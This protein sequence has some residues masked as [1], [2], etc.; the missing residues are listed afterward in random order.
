MALRLL[1]T[2]AALLAVATSCSRDPN[3]V[4]R[5]YLENGNKYFDRGKYREAS[6]MYRTALQKDAKFGEAYYRLALTNLKMRS[7]TSAIQSLRRAVELL[8][9]EQPERMDARVKLADLY[10]DYA[11]R[12]K[13]ETGIIEEAERTTADL[14][15]A[16]PK[17]FDGHRLKG[18]MALLDAQDALK[19]HVPEQVKS[20]IGVAIS[21]FQLANKVKPDDT[22]LLVLLARAYSASAQFSEAEKIYHRLVE[23]Q[24]EFLPAYMEVYRLYLVQGQFD[25]GEG[26]LKKAIEN[27]PKKYDLQLDLAA[28]YY[29]RK[30]RDDVV[31]VL[32][33][34]KSKAKAFPEVYERVGGFYFRLGDGA[35]AIRQYE[36]G[37]RA[38]G[39]KKNF[40]RKLIIEVLM[41]QGKR[42]EAKTLNDAILAADPKD[43]DALGLQGALLLDKGDLQNA[44]VQL[45]AVV[46]RAPDNFVAHFNLARGLNDKGDYEQARSHFNEAIRL[47]PDYTA[48]RIGLG[49][50]QLARREWEPA[51]KTA[52]EI[53]AYDSQNQSAALIESGALMGSGQFGP[54]REALKRLLGANPSSQDGHFQMGLLNMSEGKFK[55]AEE[56]YRRCYDLNPANSRGLMG[57]VELFMIQKQPDRAMKLLRE[58]MQKFPTRLEL[59]L[60][61]ANVMVRDQKYSQAIA[62]F[63]GLLDKVDRKSTAAADLYVRLGEAQRRTGDTQAGID[64]LKKARDLMP[65]SAMVLNTLALMLD[66]AGQKKEAKAM[67]EGALRVESENAIAL[68][69]LAYIIAESPGGDLD[70]A[71]TFAQR[72]KQKMPQVEEIADTLGWIYLKKNLAD[73]AIEIFRG[74]VIRQPKHPTFRYHLGMALYQ[75]GDK[76]KAKQELQQALASSPSKEEE[77]SIK[78]LIAKIG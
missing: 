10:L 30:R 15:K 59:R 51:I 18:R 35:E 29:A 50:L 60:A 71:L 21:E 12:V 27:N 17:S 76:V 26:V 16:D 77:A 20:E 1:L 78:E 22:D 61:L 69:N 72:A 52:R 24:K 6:I 28:F 2:C 4:K 66:G 70:Q 32:Q 57:L 8:T 64:S 25:K 44:I 3:V 37:M 46:A 68:N 55:D 62:E 7:T 54:S 43:A 14:L 75:K 58:E 19:R 47:R 5:R 38:N 48:A 42:E 63:N 53:N 36:D 67:Y 13:R 40:Y 39:D 9:P 73:N 34:L 45:Q 49:R 23:N 41:A 11:E 65:N 31:K 56:S 33:E 74:N